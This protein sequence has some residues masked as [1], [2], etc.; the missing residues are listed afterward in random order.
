MAHNNYQ[1]LFVKAVS[2]DLESYCSSKIDIWSLDKAWLNDDHEVEEKFP[3]VCKYFFA[4]P[5]GKI[6][7]IKSFHH[8]IVTEGYLSDHPRMAS[9]LTVVLNAILDKTKLYFHNQPEGKKDWKV[10]MRTSFIKA[11]SA[12]V[13]PDMVWGSTI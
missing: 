13:T 6:T 2:V 7:T 5:V 1:D 11:V 8:N 4:D 9:G 10:A 3:E 12:A